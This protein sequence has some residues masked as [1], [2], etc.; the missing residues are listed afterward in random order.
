MDSIKSSVSFPFQV[1]K[2][3]PIKEGYLSIFFFL[4]LLK[5]NMKFP[6]IDL[7]EWKKISRYGNN[8]NED[9]RHI[10]INSKNQSKSNNLMVNQKY[11]KA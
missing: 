10:K 11:Y 2:S 1:D 5:I 6:E 9:L 4:R 3:V 8:K 7:I